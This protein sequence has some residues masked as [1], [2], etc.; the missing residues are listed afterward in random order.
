MTP[1]SVVFGIFGAAALATVC[2]LSAQQD[3]APSRFAVVDV[4]VDSVEPLA[5]W[6]FELAEGSGS[7]QVVG[8]EG[9]NGAG[10]AEPPYY[11]RAAVANGEADRVI[12]AN[13][14]LRTTLE[15]PRGRTKVAT[16]HVRLRGA[17]PPDYELR[18]VAAG[19]ADGRPIEAKISLDARTGR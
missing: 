12:V 1:R 4:Y 10:F 8:I 6:Q 5:A 16:V 11:D 14:S 9:G 3:F 18:L 17:A 15:L 13:F 2:G 7:M 19:A